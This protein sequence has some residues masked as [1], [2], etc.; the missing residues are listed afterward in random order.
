[1]TIS[2]TNLESLFQRDL[3]RVLDA[4]RNT[5]KRGLQ[6][7][8]DDLPWEKKGNDR[9]ELL[10]FCLQFV[11]K[12]ILQTVSDSVEKCR[13][14]SLKILLKIAKI[15]KT[16][17]FELL[18]EINNKL[19]ERIIEIPFPEVA[20]ELRLL[21]IEMMQQI[22]VKDHKLRQTNSSESMSLLNSTIVDK[23]L[24]GV[25]K[26]LHDN[27][28]S[29]K[30][31]CGDLICLISDISISHL[32]PHAKTLIKGLIS[33]A[34]HQHSKTRQITL[35]ALG[36]CLCCLD[37]EAYRNTLTESV[38][39]LFT[40]SL[41]DRTP[42]VR[43]E[44]ASVLSN[45]IAYRLQ[46]CIDRK[47]PWL[48]VDYELLTLLLL[49][50]GDEIEEVS[51]AGK[52]RL[53][54]ALLVWR[55]E[56]LPKTMQ[57]DENE[58]V[59]EDAESVLREANGDIIDIPINNI[60]QSQIE[61]K[62]KED[63]ITLFFTENLLE[64]LE[65]LLRGID[66]WTSEA[67]IR[68]F[69]GLQQFLFII[70]EGI[71]SVLPRVLMS[72]A[73]HIRDNESEVRVV[74][75][76]VT[77]TLGSVCNISNALDYLLPRV[78]AEL[79]GTDTPQARAAAFRLLTQI[80]KGYL[81]SP[82]LSMNTYITSFELISNK[83][84]DTNLLQQRDVI[85]R[86]AF[87][88]CIRQLLDIPSSCSIDSLG[89]I[90]PNLALSLIY[91]QGKCPTE[92]DNVSEI[93]KKEMFRLASLSKGSNNDP[94]V[95]IES[96]LVPL[97]IFLLASILLPNVL[98]SNTASVSSLLDILKDPNTLSS[99]S[100]E[101]STPH[102]AAFEVLVTVCNRAT[103]QNMNIIHPFLKKQAQPKEQPAANSPEANM[104]SYASQRG[105]ENIPSLAEVDVRLSILLILETMIR[106]ATKDWECSKPLESSA[107]AIIHDI[108]MPN[109]IW[110][111]G[112]V[113]AT[114]RK[115]A[116]AIAYN[117]LKAGA[118]NTNTLVAIA[119]ELVPLLVSHLD[120][121]E[122]S[123]RLMAAFS[124]TVIFDRLKGFFSDQIIREM[125]PK[126]IARLDDSNDEVRM[127]IC[128]TLKAFLS[129]GVNVQCYLGT[130]IDYSLDQLFIHL[131]DPN[132]AV[133][134]AVFQ[135]IESSIWIQ[136]DLILKKAESN[137]LS[138]R[139]P[140][141]CEKLIDAVQS[142]QPK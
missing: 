75:E 38:V 45:L 64:V 11:I 96:F 41:T 126:L 100:W 55:P 10:E 87:L 101:A 62:S 27:F 1:M 72:I 112:R 98:F 46:Y 28:P 77:E 136:S 71:D 29:V 36:K 40:R 76:K 116:L 43:V 70:R 16:V 99:I 2:K 139:S 124:L 137:R 47:F 3:N 54:E 59:I 89:S 32:R 134:Q 23:S 94:S 68:N 57:N 63:L 106:N 39:N 132:P 34:S 105:E 133:Q 24:L 90:F 114:I 53:N 4:D 17:D 142:Y 120:D 97:H 91:L 74:V 8:L 52:L 95:V 6:K 21:V 79:S 35:H 18:V 22:I 13:E 19:V 128:L 82:T 110:R 44:L 135:T 5:R 102:K 14:L 58:M 73:S 109:L 25:S 104:Q 83:F 12:N 78:V 42:I 92:V 67:K 20:E 65:I 66:T 131:D 111:V 86:E 103:W 129:C 48:D 7:L 107:Q 33:N 31:A 84:I 88:L 117:I 15:W 130:L 119:S 26:A 93:A 9:K 125:Y 122:S 85:V 115:V 140:I 80:W 118:V 113:E 141:F 108:I 51:K 49:I 30:R 37:L 138:H 127:A 50:A 121:M 81:T 56:C 61:T 69:H 60:E 123:P